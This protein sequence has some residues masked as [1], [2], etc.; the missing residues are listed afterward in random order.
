VMLAAVKRI[1]AD[2]V[3]VQ[4]AVRERMACANG[5][6]Y[7]CAVPVWESGIRTY[8]RACVEGP[9]FPAEVLAW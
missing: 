5:S 4:L 2:T 7:G 9:I 1:P 8:A 3:S 6:C